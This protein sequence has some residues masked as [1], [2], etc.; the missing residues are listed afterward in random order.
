MVRL[1]GSFFDICFKFK[2]FMAQKQYTHVHKL[3]FQEFMRS[4]CTQNEGKV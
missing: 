2:N 1:F 3:H 4:E